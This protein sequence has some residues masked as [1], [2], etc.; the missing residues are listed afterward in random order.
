LRTDTSPKL[1]E[2]LRSVT[3]GL[4]GVAVLAASQPRGLSRCH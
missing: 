4:S 1:P 2:M 3:P